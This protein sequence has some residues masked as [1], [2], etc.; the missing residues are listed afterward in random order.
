M[1]N[2]WTMRLA[3]NAADEQPRLRRREW[4]VSNA[5][6]DVA[7]R[8]VEQF[9]YAKGASNTRTYLHGLFPVGWHWHAECVGVAWWIPPTRPA[10]ESWAGDEWT[11]V[12]ALSRLV[13]KPGIPKNACSFLL[14]GSMKLIDRTRWPVLVTYADKWRG[15]TGTIYRAAGWEYCGESAPE[16]VYT[17]DGRMVA[18]K[19]GQKTRTHAEMVAMGA[20]L[21][22]RFPKARFRH[23]ENGRAR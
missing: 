1:P 11:G 22:G 20:V 23:I 19:A 10:A 9:H 21:E 4:T 12:L 16:A 14:R 18:R 6:I 8:L 3:G 7:R 13:V 5:D 17:I 15:H 2:E